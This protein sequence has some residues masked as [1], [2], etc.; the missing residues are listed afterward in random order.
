MSDTYFL[1]VQHYFPDTTSIKTRPFHDSA[2]N[3]NNSASKSSLLTLVRAKVT[4]NKTEKAVPEKPTAVTD[5]NVVSL[6]QLS[7]SRRLS[8]TVINT[9]FSIYCE[10]V[11][12]KRQ[13]K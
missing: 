10:I 6:T 12:R 11:I 4:Q 5:T 8:K 13:M 1:I 9:Q 2:E 3:G 7:G